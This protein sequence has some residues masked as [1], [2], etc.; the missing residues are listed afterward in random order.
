[1]A[2]TGAYR[3]PH[4]LCALFIEGCTGNRYGHA[5]SPTGSFFNHHRGKGIFLAGNTE[6]SAKQV[7][8]YLMPWLQVDKL[9]QASDTA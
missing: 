7:P 8:S 2:T 1:M 3:F 4:Y 9:L 6:V 5:G